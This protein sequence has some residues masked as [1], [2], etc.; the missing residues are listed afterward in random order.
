MSV[1][2]CNNLTGNFT[3]D[4]CDIKPGQI[5][6]F[7]IIDCDYYDTMTDFT[8]LGQWTTGLTSGDIHKFDVSE[9]SMAEASPNFVPAPG[10][11]FQILTNSDHSGTLKLW[12]LTSDNRDFLNSLN[13]TSSYYGAF[14]V[15]T[16]N[17]SP[18]HLI[19]TQPV[20]WFFSIPVE[21]DKGSVVKFSGTFAWKDIDMPLVKAVPA[22]LYS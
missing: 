19:S 20:N 16:L 15:G 22:G 7:S 5:R 14:R 2:D 18:V 1:Y 10:D 9:G 12:G 3:I 8:A 4:L 13:K 6:G 17:G 11:A 21:E